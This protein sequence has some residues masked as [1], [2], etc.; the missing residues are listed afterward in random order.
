[1][2][3]LCI[4]GYPF[5]ISAYVNP[6]KQSLINQNPETHKEDTVW[7]DTEAVK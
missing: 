7:T 3:T 1:M 5:S 4:S 2:S 6:V